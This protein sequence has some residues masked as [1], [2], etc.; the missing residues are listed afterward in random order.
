MGEPMLGWQL[1]RSDESNFARGHSS[2]DTSGSDCDPLEAVMASYERATLQQSMSDDEAID[3]DNDV[4]C[5]LQA[6]PMYE[7]ESGSEFDLE[8]LRS[9]P[10]DDEN[11]D[12]LMS[13]LL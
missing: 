4:F 10:N 11:L 7:E 6:L 13:S 12:T 3:A 5:R 2:D 9:M 1:T 8:V